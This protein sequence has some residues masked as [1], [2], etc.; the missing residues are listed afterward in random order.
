LIDGNE[1]KLNE[2]VGYTP[3]VEEFY[4]WLKTGI[5]NYKKEQ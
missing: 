2:P 5:D 4:K 3:D 1:R